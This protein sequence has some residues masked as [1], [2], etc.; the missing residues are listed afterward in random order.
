LKR[1]HI[2][3]GLHQQ[4]RIQGKVTKDEGI[5]LEGS[6]ELRG[7]QVSTF[8]SDSQGRTVWRQSFHPQDGDNGGS[9]RYGEYEVNVRVDIRDQ[10]VDIGIIQK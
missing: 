3:I 9:Y 6:A 8:L 5:A 1:K 7:G 4:R 2:Y 10:V